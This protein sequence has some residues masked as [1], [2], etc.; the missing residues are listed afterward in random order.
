MWIVTTIRVLR[1]DTPQRHEG[2]N[3]NSLGN[4]PWH[5]EGWAKL[6]HRRIEP[7]RDGGFSTN[8][9][10]DLPCPSERWERIFFT[11]ACLNG[12]EG[13]AGFSPL[14]KGRTISFIIYDPQETQR[15]GCM[16]PSEDWDNHS[17]RGPG[18]LRSLAY[19]SVYTDIIPILCMPLSSTM[20][21]LFP[22]TTVCMYFLHVTLRQRRISFCIACCCV[23]P[24]WDDTF[25]KISC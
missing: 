3:T 4:L 1:G 19:N 13:R 22:K 24:P 7:K 21:H 9:S 20:C 25:P 14:V 18:Y 23:K 12:P 10:G 15:F 17:G 11:G 6:C 16:I 8:S 2:S 5:R